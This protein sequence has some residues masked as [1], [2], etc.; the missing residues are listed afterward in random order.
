[1]NSGDWVENMTSLEYIN[2]HW[3][4]YRYGVDEDAG[5]EEILTRL[6][7][8]QYIFPQSKVEKERE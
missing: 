3:K 8:D 1:M 4:L 2:G 6:E 7:D 5:L